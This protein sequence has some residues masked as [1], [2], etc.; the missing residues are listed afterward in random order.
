[1]E[2]FLEENIRGDEIR[3]EGPTSKISPT[4]AIGEPKFLPLWRDGIVGETIG[5]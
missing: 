2:L 4:G 3:M 5:P 1:M